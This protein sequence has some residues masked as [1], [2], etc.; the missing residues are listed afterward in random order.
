MTQFKEGNNASKGRPKGSKNKR[1]KI[2][3]SLAAEALRQLENAV[4]SAEP[5][6]I[7]EVLKRLSPTL[8][9]ITPLDSL[10]GQFLTLKMK[11]ISEFESRLQALENNETQK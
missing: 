8:K 9:A 10:D 3:D 6:A 5:W 7:T 2:T 11:E 4:C 1:G